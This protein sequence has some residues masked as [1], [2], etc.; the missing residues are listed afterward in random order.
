MPRAPR[1][2][3]LVP[4][5]DEPPSP[6]H[7]TARP[8]PPPRP[9]QRAKLGVLQLA[10]H[11]QHRQSL[12]HGGQTSRQVSH[13]S[14]ATSATNAP[15]APPLVVESQRYEEWMKLST[16]NKI[17]STNTWSLALIDYFHD[18]SLLRN[19]DG[20]D[21]INF[22]KASCTLD[23]CVKI[24]T[25]RVDSVATETGKLLSGL[26]EG[27]DGQDSNELDDDGEGGSDSE[28]RE[29]RRAKKRA[30]FPPRYPLSPFLT[31]LAARHTS[32]LADSFS[33][34]SVKQFDLEFTV[35]PLFKKTSA[36][37]DEG[38]A[39][40]ILMNHLG[41]DGSMRVVFDA[42]DAK[43]E[44]GDEEDD[45]DQ[46]EGEEEEEEE[47][48]VEVD[49]EKL[50]EKCLPE[51]LATLSS[52]HLTPSL[53]SFSFSSS[54]SHKGNAPSSLLLD[55]LNLSSSASNDDDNEQQ[56]IAHSGS[57]ATGRRGAAEDEE[58]FGGFEPRDFGGGEGEDQ[59]M[60]EHFD[61]DDYGG[62]G[63]EGG[64][65]DFFADEMT[66][67]Q[68]Y[69][70]GGGG[71]P[72]FGPVTRFDPRLAASSERDLVLAM[73]AQDENA[74]STRNELG[75]GGVDG[76]F[77]YFD[78]TM[79][80]NW[81]GPQ[82]WKMRRGAYGKKDVAESAAS[83][84]G[85]EGGPTKRAR[86]EKV[87]FVLDFTVAPPLSK[88]EL[89]LPA[90]PKSSI[91]LPLP[92]FSSSSSS[93]RGRTVKG[94]KGKVPSDQDK[95]KAREQ[96]D[97]TLPDDHHFNSNHLLRL[98]LKPRTTLRMRRRGPSTLDS[99]ASEDVAFWAQPGS[100]DPSGPSASGRP[101]GSEGVDGG[102]GGAGGE[103]AGAIGGIGVLP[104]G[105]NGEVDYG[106]F[107]GGDF[108]GGGGEDDFPPPF[109]TQWLA[110]ADNDD[111]DPE[112]D[113]MSEAEQDLAALTLG[114]HNSLKRVKVEQVNYAKRAKRIDVKRLKDS[115]WKE[116][117]EVAL[118]V[119]KFPSALVYEPA[120]PP[121]ELVLSSDDDED[122]GQDEG[123][124][125]TPKSSTRRK[126]AAKRE[127]LLPVVSSLRRQYP[128]D[129][130][131][132]I[133]TSYM[134]ICLLH[135]ANE[136][137]LRIQTPK[138]EFD[139]GEDEGSAVRRNVGGL[140]SLRVLKEVGSH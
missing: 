135:L 12:G 73:D 104:I 128:T 80:K 61:Q 88:E 15:A 123:D 127:A 84:A 119:R 23:G 66:P 102:A 120:A 74:S 31:S 42:G 132:E 75:G 53:A 57:G 62:G 30:S 25:S 22:Q 67:A 24:W 65:V 94:R 93:S 89:F 33:K 97:H 109:D 99:A 34:L 28:E 107:D 91:T 4:L 58:D 110:S 118:P 92:V 139:D 72:G 37:F 6:D 112:G 38:G 105:E 100:F 27:K 3:S 71:G 85:G 32:T 96:E 117:E 18:M 121:E 95:D 69:Q 46:G 136:K 90:Q 103:G 9:P 16:D 101:F 35:D 55:L 19:G 7:S 68:Q 115:I 111:P 78:G 26:G 126:Q 137:G 83:A 2:S 134:F 51:N 122:D 79:R 20:D 47:E 50:R 52:M 76:L 64:E 138:V 108:G 45:V 41:C 17:T 86:K 113:P 36:D 116:L 49:I 43:V 13:S 48:G 56:G 114:Q 106:G 131:S 40:G 39:G 129:K 11:R 133:S 140:E 130:M 59:E 44:G 124:D 1:K 70:G 60:L 77:D 87:P 14:T 63:G 82:H 98:F 21:S 10:Q 29:A 54:S 125:S 8:P 5:N 81:A